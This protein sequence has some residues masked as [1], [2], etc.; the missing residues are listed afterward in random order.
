[1]KKHLTFS[2][3][4]LLLSSFNVQA[5]Q[6]EVILG[7]DIGQN[8][9]R[10]EDDFI[11]A[12]TEDGNHTAF[13]LSYVA[14]YHFANDIV[15]EAN[16][17]YS[18]NIN[19]LNAFDRYSLYELKGL[20]GYSFT[21]N[22]ALTLVPMI[23]FSKWDLDTKEGALLNSGPEAEENF[24]GIDVAYKLRLNLAFDSLT[25]MSLSYAITEAD[26]GRTQAVQVG[27]LFEF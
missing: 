25:M 5:D 16:L 20:V 4:A 19:I 10:F 3:L 21:L 8:K 11:V 24:D 6:G 2:I 12:D 26:F 7:F 23:G 9:M 15:A 18:S 17:V 1:M 22:Q 27:L 14:G 13:S